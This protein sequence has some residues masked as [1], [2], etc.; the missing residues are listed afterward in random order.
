LVIPAPVSAEIDYLL[1]TRLGARAQRAF[2]AD[3]A[4]ERFVVACLQTIDYRRFLELEHRY[5]GLELGLADLAV[6]VMADRFE[7]LRILTFD[8]RDFRAVSPLQGG[9]FE[10][11]PADL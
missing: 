2:L 3:L 5:A 8:E 9:S 10:L 4:A 11:L 7:T 6:I 1:A